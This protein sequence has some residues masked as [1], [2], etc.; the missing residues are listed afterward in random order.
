VARRRGPRGTWGKGPPPAPRTT[1]TPA[2]ID[3]Q[4]AHASRI[5]DYLLGGTTNFAIDRQMAEDVFGIYAGGIDAARVDVRANR[6]F[7]GRTVRYLAAQAGIRQFLDIGTG[8]PTQGNVHEVAQSVAPDSRVVYVD[9]DLIVRAH[10]GALLESTPEGT[11]AYLTV[12]LREP[13]KILEQAKG[14]LDFRQPVA[15]MLVGILHAVPDDDDAYGI[16]TR[17]L[18]ALPPGSHL[19]L[20]HLASDINEDEMAMAFKLLNERSHETFVLRDRTGVSRFFDTLELLDPGVVTIDQ[21]RSDEKRSKRP[22]H[23]ITPIYGA[24]GRKR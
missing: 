13:E 2:E 7:L 6:A 15:L 24:V 21:W 3:T 1:R 8:I 4:V 14:T 23:S 12:D 18:E 17:L 19:V 16:V 11:T 10:A 20:S 9:Y 22:G 5:Y